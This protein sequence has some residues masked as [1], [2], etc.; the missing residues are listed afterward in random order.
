MG[1]FWNVENPVWKFIGRLADFFCLSLLWALCS[2]PVVTAGAATT[3]LYDVVMKM[4]EDQEGKLAQGFLMS[5]RSNLPKATVLW[6]GFLLVGALLFLDGLWAL[7]GSGPL[8]LAMFFF[9]LSLGLAWLF[10]L[11]FVFALLARVEN[12]AWSLVKMAGAIV[13]R[14][15]LP[16]FTGLVLYAAFASAGLFVAWPLLLVVPALPAYLSGRLFLR[17]LER[18]GL[19]RP[20][21]EE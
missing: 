5:F 19:R 14:N 10:T 20:R 13:S 1:Q 15:L 21:E 11:S 16:I 6:L 18:Y 8:H 2:L 4:A 12:G 3:A 17:I 7:S 9:A